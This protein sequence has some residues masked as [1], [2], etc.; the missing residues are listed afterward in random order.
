MAVLVREDL[1]KQFIKNEISPVY[2]FFGAEGF[3]RDEWIKA[4]TNRV[5]K[6]SPLREFNEA[7]FSL[8][9][10]DIRHALATAE[11][12]PM[13]GD[14]R[15][16]KVT[17]VQKVRE[18]D[19]ESLSRYLSNPAESCV[20]ILVASELDKRKRVSKL[21]LE[22]TFAVEFAELKD[23]E[24]VAWAKGQ[25]KNLH[26]SADDRTLSYLVGLVG[27][28]VRRL[29]NELEKIAVASLPEGVITT[30]L[31][32]EL[33]PNSREISNFALT[34]YLLTKNRPKALQILKKILDDG[35]E[36]LMLLGLIA[37]NYHRLALVKDMMRKGY[38]NKEVFRVVAMPFNKQEEFKAT[39]RRVDAKILDKSLQRIAQ[40]DLAIKTS[41]ATPRMQIE[42]LVYE[43]TA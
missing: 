38:D 39:A 41:Q 33:V 23:G 26:T 43:L 17:E 4:I 30:K 29:S 12:L 5:L 13:M 8:N 6:D 15:V 20:L 14:R 42:M 36:P 1:R 18:E 35:A 3:L 40:T 25:L 24:L 31:I 7:E 11:Q 27:N 21:L 34:D 28:N 22:K 19:E 10:N 9:D 2:L 37:A 16:V 32:D